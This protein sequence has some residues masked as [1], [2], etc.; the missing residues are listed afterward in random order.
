MA[1]KRLI[2]CNSKSSPKAT[3]IVW[4]A[5]KN[6]LATKER[7]LKWN[8]QIDGACVLCQSL[9]ENLEHLFFECSFSSFIWRSV[10]QRLG[11]FRVIQHWQK[12]VEWAAKK[13]IST[14]PKDKVCSMAL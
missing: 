10:L 13:S 3:F 14:K 2:N 11:M 9:T 12:E 4:L 5:L 6:R 1:W 8:M 7:L